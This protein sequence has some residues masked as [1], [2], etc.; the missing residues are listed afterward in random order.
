MSP[1]SCVVVAWRS[2]R[3]RTVA[4]YAFPI[5]SELVSTIGECSSPH[6]AIWLVPISSPNPFRMSVPA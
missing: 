2:V 5:A 4:S 3:H 6:S 1:P